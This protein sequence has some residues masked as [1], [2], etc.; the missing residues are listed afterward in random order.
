MGE[1]DSLRYAP[2]TCKSP[3]AFLGPQW[4]IAAWHKDSLIPSGVK[5]EVQAKPPL[6]TARNARALI[7]QHRGQSHTEQ[8]CSG[9]SRDTPAQPLA[10]LSDRECWGRQEVEGLELSQLYGEPELPP[11][12]KW[13]SVSA[14]PLRPSESLNFPL[15]FCSVSL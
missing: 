9:F 3:Q 8:H 14:Q 4:E 15:S 12:H 6:P 7:R 11:A 2:Y 13:E 5:G 1:A 10:T